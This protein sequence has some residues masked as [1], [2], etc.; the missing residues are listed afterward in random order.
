M[1]TSFFLLN[2]FV[3]KLPLFLESFYLALAYSCHWIARETYRY[4]VKLEYLPLSLKIDSEVINILG[5]HRLKQ[6]SKPTARIKKKCAFYSKSHNV[7]TLFLVFCLVRFLFPHE[8]LI[9]NGLRIAF[10]FTRY[11]HDTP[12]RMGFSL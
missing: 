9:G 3:W 1:D 4:L 12:I 5:F 2:T 10:T 11:L 6:K 7:S 8:R